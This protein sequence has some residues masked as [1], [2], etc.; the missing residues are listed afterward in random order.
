[1]RNEH[2]VSAKLSVHQENIGLAAVF[3]IWTMIKPQLHEVTKNKKHK[4]LFTQE[5]FLDQGGGFI[6]LEKCGR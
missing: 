3:T 5:T 1:M 2:Y 6:V 4:P